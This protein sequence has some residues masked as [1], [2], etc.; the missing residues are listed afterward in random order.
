MFDVDMVTGSI[1]D[2][3]DDGILLDDDEAASRGAGVGD[4]VTF[5]FLDGSTRT[6][7]RRWA[8]EAP[9]WPAA[10]FRP[11]ADDRPRGSRLRFRPSH[12]QAST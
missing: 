12:S 8:E 3:R 7:A 10:S 5:A 9:G 11:P 1:A 2:L 6:E 4:T